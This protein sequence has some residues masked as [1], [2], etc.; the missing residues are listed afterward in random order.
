[1]TSRRGILSAQDVAEACVSEAGFGDRGASGVA[2][3]DRKCRNFSWAFQHPLHMRIVLG[4]CLGINR[5]CR[6][7]Q[8]VV[9][10]RTGVWN[11]GKREQFPSPVQ[12]FRVFSGCDCL[13]G[14][15]SIIIGLPSSTTLLCRILKSC[16]STGCSFASVRRPHTKDCH[17]SAFLL[18]TTRLAPCDAPNSFLCCL[19]LVLHQYPATNQNYLEVQ[20]TIYAITPTQ[21]FFTLVFAPE[22]GKQC[23][24][25]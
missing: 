18:L 11:R 1:M 24:G 13:A 22:A 16:S 5:I 20:T 23:P 12:V 15:L 6:Q 4:S 3:E 7:Y 9:R 21:S 25:Q 17:R 10:H 8:I 14:F 19:S 2:G